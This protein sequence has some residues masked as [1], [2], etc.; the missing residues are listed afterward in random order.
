MAP[1]M[2]PDQPFARSEPARRMRPSGRR[3]SAWWRVYQPGRW[4]AQVPRA[5]S[6]ASQSCAAAATAEADGGH[7][8]VEL[9]LDRRGRG[10]RLEQRAGV[11]D[12]RHPAARVLGEREAVPREGMPAQDRDRAGVL[13]RCVRQ[14]LEL[15][16]E[17]GT[18]L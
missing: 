9:R 3:I 13:E 1:S 10:D 6:S 12:E 11:L 16:L 7:R 2:K 4:I 17:H 5:Y 8:R 15:R 18:L 14:R